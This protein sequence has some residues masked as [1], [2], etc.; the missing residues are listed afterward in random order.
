[1]SL[2]GGDRSPPTHSPVTVLSVR[3]QQAS[4]EGA[5]GMSRESAC[6]R[7]AVTTR[8]VTGPQRVDPDIRANLR[9]RGPSALRQ[10]HSYDRYRLRD[11]DSAGRGSE[12]PA[13]HI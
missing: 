5:H 10:L 3:R 6:D 9:S 1:M 11:H 2:A 13:R 8:E 7:E 12:S 4:D